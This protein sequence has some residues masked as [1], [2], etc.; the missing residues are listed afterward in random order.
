MPPKTTICLQKVMIMLFSKQ[1]VAI[2]KER[3]Y[4]QQTP[5]AASGS[6]PAIKKELS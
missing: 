2:R 6:N 5:D 1:L 3:E 4:T